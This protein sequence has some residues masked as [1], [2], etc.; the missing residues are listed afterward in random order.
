M[1]DRLLGIDVDNTIFD[2]DT[3]VNAAMLDVCGVEYEY[4]DKSH[5]D[6][7][8]DLAPEDG[9]VEALRLALDPTKVMERELYPGVVEA[10]EELYDDGIRPHFITHNFFDPQ[11]MRNALA[12]WLEEVI[13]VPFGLS[14][15]NTGPKLTVMRRIDAF[16]ILDDKPDF[17]ES[18]AD[19][20]L[21]AAT[22]I[23]PWNREVV[24][25][26]SDVHGFE[27]WSEVPGLLSQLGKE[28]LLS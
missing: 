28:S 20:G 27:H 16:G 25:R 19:A 11:R 6:Y 8:F 10:L 13:T 24:E 17:I 12:M 3:L 15:V 22:K 14:V 26:R 2:F 21:F 5:W 9:V 23:H 7:W 1:H 18:V 4:E